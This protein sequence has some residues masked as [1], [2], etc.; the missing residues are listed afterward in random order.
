MFEHKIFPPMCSE[1]SVITPKTEHQPRTKNSVRTQKTV[2]EPALANHGDGPGRGNKRP[3][4]VRSFN[5]GGRPD[6]VRA[7]NKDGRM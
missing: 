3:D 2:Q 6:N 1:N 4:N 5:K 7:V